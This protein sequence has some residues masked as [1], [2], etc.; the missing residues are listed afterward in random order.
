MGL[1][2]TSR[3]ATSFPRGA[4]RKIPHTNVPKHSVTTP[5]GARCPSRRR[6]L[7]STARQTLKSFP[8]TQ[9]TPHTTQ[10]TQSYST[11]SLNKTQTNIND[12]PCSVPPQTTTNP[13][14]N[15]VR[16][17]QPP[18]AAVTK[19]RR[20]QRKSSRSPFKTTA[21]CGYHLAQHR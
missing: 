21:C 11:Q 14:V 3:C 13:A 20:R 17:H 10:S 9:A 15:P 1:H 7:F 18:I 19:T 5:L 6:A 8:A 4:D 12:I 2:D 16:M